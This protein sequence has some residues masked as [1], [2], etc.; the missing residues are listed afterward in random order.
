MPIIRS[1]WP[2]WALKPR[3]PSAICCGS[4]G[5]LTCQWPATASRSSGSSLSYGEAVMTP[6]RTPGSRAALS[7]NRLVASSRNG[8]TKAAVT[9]R[10]QYRWAIAGA[11]ASEVQRTPGLADTGDVPAKAP[12]HAT[13]AAYHHAMGSGMS[14]GFLACAACGA[15]LPSVAKFC[16]ECGSPLPAATD[17][18]TRRTVTL[19]FTD[20]TG[21]T[22]MGEQLDPEAYRSVMG[23]Y[24]AVA[25][26]AIERHG[27][28][29]EKF[30]GDAVLAVF[31]LPEVHEDDALRAVRAADELN[32]AVAGLS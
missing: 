28:T 3:T 22:A 14:T 8:A 6:S 26:D 12:P 24:F 7:T 31:G 17:R 16:L 32:E 21:S 5:S 20:V 30:V 2:S 25:R 15:E 4:R 18:E 29:V 11:E 10:E 27:G 23:R 9:M 1:T 13:R 19:L